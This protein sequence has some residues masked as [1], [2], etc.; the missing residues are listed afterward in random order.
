MFEE[1]HQ[2]F[3][4]GIVVTVGKV[5]RQVTLLQI[6]A[7]E[8]NFQIATTCKVKISEILVHNKDVYMGSK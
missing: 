4:A 3:Q 5:Q 8:Q 1:N 6:F 2:Q 7:S